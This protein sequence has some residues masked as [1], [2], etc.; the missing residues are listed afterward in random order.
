[1]RSSK[2]LPRNI[3][4]SAAG[5]IARFA[6][7]FALRKGADVDRLLRKAGLSRAQMDNPNARVRVKSQIKFLDL[8]AE[9]IDDDLLGFHLSLHFDLRM[10]GLLY[11]V[12]ASSETL[13]DALRNGARCSPIVN[14]SIRLKVHEGKRRI[15][16]VFEPFGI[17]RR[18][19]LAMPRGHIRLQ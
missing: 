16:F 15:G 4:I 18:A 19:L 2:S 12:F 13:D 9:A 11:Y 8:V 14:E 7:D 5:N 3:Q 17:A 6:Y 1:M 10:A